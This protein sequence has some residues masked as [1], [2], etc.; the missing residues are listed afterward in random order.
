MSNLFYDAFDG[1]GEALTGRP[2]PPLHD[3]TPNGA[4]CIG[5]PGGSKPGCCQHRPASVVYVAGPERIVYVR[6]AGIFARLF[7]HLR[8]AP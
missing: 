4:Y 7:R 5:C 1:W 2:P 8:G 6:S 3:P